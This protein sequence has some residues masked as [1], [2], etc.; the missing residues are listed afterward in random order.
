MMTV[1]GII[2]AGIF[3]NPAIVAERTG[4]A[5]A[6][7]ASWVLGGAIALAGAL[8]FAELGSR[9]PRAGG[10]YVYLRDAFG[11]LPAFLY[12]W[13]L[14]LVINS[15]ALAAVAAIA[16]RYALDL[17]GAPARLALPL[18]LV[19]IWLFTAVNYVG[20]RPGAVTQNLFTL[21]KLGALAGLILIGCFW[22]T[23]S[24]PVEASPAAPLDW[25]GTLV[26]VG[27]ALIPVMFAT[28]GWQN[29]N[30]IAAEIRDAR[31]TLPRAIVSGVVIVV[32]V[33]VLAN[34]AYLRILGVGGLAESSAPA[35]DTLAV[36]AGATAGRWISLGIVCSTLGILN[37]FVLAAPR[38]Y[39]AMADDGL[40][41]RRASRLHPR[42]RTPAGALL[43]QAVW[44]SVLAASGTYGQLLDYVVFGDWIFFGSVAATLWV[45]R[46]REGRGEPAADTDDGLPFRTP[47]MPLVTGA[48][49][50]A[51]VAIVAASIYSNPA[52]AALGGVL[53][54]AGVPV[55]AVWR[56]RS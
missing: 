19:F 48:F 4:T 10:G 2:G 50:L 3:L 45:Y 53:I 30:F 16:A 12:G 42:Y 35:A 25:S 29:S 36:A 1:G 37:L 40:F 33:Y 20:I 51:A 44:A 6:T 8:C 31:R 7:L 15:G 18:G 54:A 43:F 38:V 23:P 24:M 46:A 39:Q 34:V 26:A 32:V 9:F 14:L 17:M 55:Y 56:R 41:F 5:G 27:T 22:P 13:T 47:A 21:L 52:N 11:R 28:G 49:V